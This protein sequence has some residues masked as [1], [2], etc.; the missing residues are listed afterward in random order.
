VRCCFL[1]IFHKTKQCIIHSFIDSMHLFS[2][3]FIN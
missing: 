3:T 2:Y 1:Y